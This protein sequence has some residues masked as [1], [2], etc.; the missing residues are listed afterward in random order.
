MPLHFSSHARSRLWRVTALLLVLLMAIGGYPWSALAQEAETGV[1]APSEE[2][3][4]EEEQPPSLQGEQAAE[5]EAGKE[6]TETAPRKDEMPAEEEPASEEEPSQPST[7]ETDTTSE[8][9]AR[10]G[11][12]SSSQDGKSADETPDTTPSA[13]E[14]GA[15]D[16]PARRS[17]TSANALE[18][19]SAT[20]ELPPLERRLPNGQTEP[21]FPCADDSA[22][23]C[24]LVEKEWCIYSHWCVAPNTAVADCWFGGVDAEG[25]PMM[26]CLPESWNE[27]CRF[28]E[29]W[30]DGRW[31]RGS[32]ACVSGCS[33]ETIESCLG[34]DSC[35]C[36]SWW[37]PERCG[38]D[39]AWSERDWEWWKNDPS[40]YPSPCEPSDDHW[41]PWSCDGSPAYALPHFFSPVNSY[42]DSEVWFTTIAPFLPS[43]TDDLSV[44]DYRPDISGDPLECIAATSFPICLPFSRIPFSPDSPNRLTPNYI[45]AAEAAGYRYFPTLQ[46]DGLLRGGTDVQIHAVRL[47]AGYLT[48]MDAVGASSARLDISDGTHAVTTG[49]AV[50]RLS[51]SATPGG[52]PFMTVSGCWNVGCIGSA[53]SPTL[54][55]T[56][57][58]PGH[59]ARTATFVLPP[60]AVDLLSRDTFAGGGADFLEAFDGLVRPILDQLTS[61]QGPLPNL[62]LVLGDTSLARSDDTL[63]TTASAVFA[64]VLR[65]G[66]PV[67]VR[68]AV[69]SVLLD[70]A[71]LTA[72]TERRHFTSPSSDSVHS[73]RGKE[74]G[75]E[76]QQFAGGAAAKPPPG[77]TGCDTSGVK[78]S[79]PPQPGGNNNSNGND[80]GGKPDPVRDP[81]R[82]P[83]RTTAAG[84]QR[85]SRSVAALDRLLASSSPRDTDTATG[86]GADRA[87]LA[88]ADGPAL[89]TDPAKDA[90]RSASEPKAKNA[91][92]AQA[93][94]DSPPPSGKLSGLVPPDSP[95]APIVAGLLALSLL[96]AG[97]AHRFGL[98]ARL[99]RS[100]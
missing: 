41:D 93:A 84:P 30:R 97:G 16:S 21:T 71:E 75:R 82:S 72:R 64:S 23:T 26:E 39:A 13:S 99:R 89:E 74:A 92:Q 87:R 100:A 20:S 78:P 88:R 47:L 81:D 57:S 55:V 28:E 14:D 38:W 80:N 12:G 95:L 29:E 98:V 69:T 56:L 31:T 10:A 25:T 60:G 66:A 46:F 83:T 76:V 52:D 86:E 15:G 19:E 63:R 62:R 37:S 40:S 54:T 70:A 51:L 61:A 32:I 67:E 94:K 65:A 9:Y 48:V 1:E 49:W 77:C 68:L 11:D 5:P 43:R 73:T 6:R 36:Y 7:E 90:A 45:A 59:E 79:V 33:V 44:V 35:H 50:D 85:P 4:P 2:Q 24:G 42:S 18:G 58:P 8:E 3:G 17:G 96:G 91:P 53:S 27:A 34:P 22:K